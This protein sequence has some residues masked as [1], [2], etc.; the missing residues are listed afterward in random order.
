MLFFFRFVF[1]ARVLVAFG[2]QLST[3]SFAIDFRHMIEPDAKISK[4]C[5]GCHGPEDRST[6]FGYF[7]RLTG[8]P[9][10]YLYNQLL[11]FQHGTRIYPQMSFLLENVNTD[12]LHQL[13]HFFA[14]QNTSYPPPTKYKGN[15]A[16]LEMGRK[17]VTQ[18]EPLLNIPA[19]TECHGFMLTG[20]VSSSIPGLLGLPRDYLVAQLGAWRTNH[21]QAQEPDCMAE[22]AKKLSLDQISAV[23]A[24]ISSQPWPKDG[25]QTAT[26]NRV[27]ANLLPVRCGSVPST[28]LSTLT[29]PDLNTPRLTDLQR[30]GQYLT[31]IGNCQSCHTAQ[32][33][34]LMAGGRAIETPFGRVYSTNLTPDFET[35]I[36]SW[37]GDD[38]WRALHEG[39][40][41]DGSYLL[42]AFPY[43]ELTQVNRSDSD[44]MFGYL[45]T[46]TPQK[47]DAIPNTLKWPYN[48]QLGLGIWRA[49]YFKPDDYKTDPL[50][51]KLW[52]RGA[53]L[54]TGLMH[55]GS[56]HTPRNFLGSSLKD[57][58]F[59]GGYLLANGPWYAPSLRMRQQAGVQGWSIPQIVNLLQNG[60][61]QHG[62]V[63][64][65]MAEVVYKGAQYLSAD[66]AQAIA[67]FLQSV[68]G[69]STDDLVKA[70]DMKDKRPGREAGKAIYEKHCESCHGKEGVGLPN[71]YPSLVDNRNVV[72]IYFNNLVQLVLLGAIPPTTASNPTPLG[73]PPYRAILSDQEVAQVLTFIRSEWGNHASPISTLD[74]LQT[75]GKVRSISRDLPG[76]RW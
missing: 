2:L 40:S 44:A 16:Q 65:P 17:M 56:C 70:S 54:V 31:R 29:I 49:L 46:L 59:A 75:A 13:A 5:T 73:M 69:S 62:Y 41:K 34:L 63:S 32:A 36:G 42:P 68:K 33:G 24:W 4:A 66:D 20:G 58:A 23:T 21:R 30:K 53:Y 14:M 72:S 11:N 45:Q 37:S 12:Y 74:V 9:E 47:K 51:T 1:W 27:K 7:P 35:G 15:K 50:Q 55:C 43:P 26:Q 48:T 3:S 57:A 67:V 61:T 71:H 22:V 25:H 6:T 52:N 10:V 8:K 39:R 76:G 60:I 28:S 38:F 18:G 19:C 64:G